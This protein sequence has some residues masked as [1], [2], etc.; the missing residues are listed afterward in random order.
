[1]PSRSDQCSR[2]R[3][4]VIAT[5]VVAGGMLAG[6]HG[7]YSYGYV[8]AEPCAPVYVAP[9]CPPPVYVAPRHH[10]GPRHHHHGGHW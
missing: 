7:T 3:A 5:L 4:I 8:A 1:M 10:H 2:T 9:S 6:C